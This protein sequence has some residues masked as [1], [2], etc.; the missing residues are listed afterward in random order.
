MNRPVG[1]EQLR[2][3]CERLVDELAVPMPLDPHGLCDRLARHRR[4]AI[5]IR[6]V[7]LGGTTTVGH[8]VTKRR[9]DLILCDAAAPSSQRSLI[10]YHEVIHLLRHSAGSAVPFTCGF[11]GPAADFGDVAV[12]MYGDWREREAETGARI[13]AAMADRR[14]RP[15]Q[16]A[17]PG[18]AE[19][20]LATTFGLKI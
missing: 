1:A 3:W 20:S 2:N 18:H 15:D 9:T 11:A 14:A 8:L 6:A 12:S 4:R 17:A 13:L 10:I 19:R 5:K 16:P 7:D